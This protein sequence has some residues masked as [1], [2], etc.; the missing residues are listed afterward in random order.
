MV[1][2]MEMLVLLARVTVIEGDCSCL[3]LRTEVGQSTDP[4]AYRLRKSTGT[5][6]RAQGRMRL[7]SYGRRVVPTRIPH[8]RWMPS[9]DA[10]GC[11]RSGPVGQRAQRARGA[12]GTA[13]RR[14]R[15]RTEKT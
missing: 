14:R 4:P 1:V 13:R 7:L 10:S 12:A 5:S 9:S 6:C 15:A 8:S 3:L 11:I 2:F